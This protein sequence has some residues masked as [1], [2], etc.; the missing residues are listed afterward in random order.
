MAVNDVNELYRSAENE[1]N[2]IIECM[3]MDKRTDKKW[4]E[5]VLNSVETAVK[6]ISL[7]LYTISI[8][9]CK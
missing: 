3:K 1:V 5:K 2:C 4:N 8:E 9:N 7:I 6:N